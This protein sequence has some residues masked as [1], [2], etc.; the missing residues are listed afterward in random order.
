MSPYMIDARVESVSEWKWNM[1]T[2]DFVDGMPR[3]WQLTY[4]GNMCVEL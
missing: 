4:V 1:I 2:I 3:I